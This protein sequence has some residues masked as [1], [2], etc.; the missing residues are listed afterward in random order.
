[1][2]QERGT[3]VITSGRFFDI[4]ARHCRGLAMPRRRTRRI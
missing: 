3:I 4:S 2:L 1:M